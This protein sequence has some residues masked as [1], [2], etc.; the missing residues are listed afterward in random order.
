MNKERGLTSST[1]SW[2]KSE[3]PEQREQAGRGPEADTVT[4]DLANT[5]HSSYTAGLHLMVLLQCYTIEE[6]PVSLSTGLGYVSYIQ[7]MSLELDDKP[8]CLSWENVLYIWIFSWWNHDN[9]AGGKWNELISGEESVRYFDWMVSK[10]TL[11]LPHTHNHV[12]P[13]AERTQLEL[14]PGVLW[15]SELQWRSMIQWLI[16]Q[17]LQAQKT[18]CPGFGLHV[19]A[20]NRDEMAD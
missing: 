19:P 11:Q 20:H 5:H 1:F 15:T 14:R 2:S 8:F 10:N 12:R 3:F 7:S 6:R 9:W 18:S 16:G 4:G 13:T 17:Y